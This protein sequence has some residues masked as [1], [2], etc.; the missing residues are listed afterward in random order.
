LAVE[1]V[2]Q[3]FMT[4]TYQ[5]LDNSF[6]G[7]ERYDL[8]DKPD[9][10]SQ[11]RGSLDSE[12]ID[13]VYVDQFMGQGTGSGGGSYRGI[14]NYRPKASDRGT[15]SCSFQGTVGAIDDRGNL[16]RSGATGA[17]SCKNKSF[18]D[19]QGSGTLDI[20][21][22]PF[23]VAV[24][25]VEPYDG[26]LGLI[27]GRFSGSVVSISANPYDIEIAGAS[28]TENQE[29]NE[30]EVTFA[31]TG[32]AQPTANRGTSIA[33]VRL[34]WATGTEP[35][36]ILGSATADKIPIYWNQAGGTI[37]VGGLPNPPANATHLL[38]YADSDQRVS[39]SIEVENNLCGLRL[40]GLRSVKWNTTRDSKA[41]RGVDVKYVVA[42]DTPL[43]VGTELIYYWASGPTLNSKI[44]QVA[45]E[46]LKSDEL[47]S[48]EHL[49][50]QPAH[51]GRPPADATHIVVELKRPGGSEPRL[52]PH[53][54]DWNP[55]QKSIRIHS[56]SEIMDGAIVPET[57]NSGK[58]ISAPF[59]PGGS[60]NW[61]IS[62]AEVVMGVDH[63]NWY[64]EV[65]YPT[66]M[67]IRDRAFDLGEFLG[68]PYI[69]PYSDAPGNP[70]NVGILSLYSAF[71]NGTPPDPLD[72]TKYANFDLM[73]VDLFDFY[74]D[75]VPKRGETIPEIQQNTTSVG[76]RYYDSP[77]VPADFYNPDANDA[78]EFK[79]EL[80]GI[81]QEHGLVRLSQVSE[82]QR[83]FRW[84]SN[85]TY[86]R[87][88]GQTGSGGVILYVPFDFI[89]ND[90]TTGGVSDIEP[91]QPLDELIVAPD[92]AIRIPAGV[93]TTLDV[94]A[95]ATMP[96]G[97]SFDL[98]SISP[99]HGTATLDD[100]GTPNDTTD[101]RITYQS[102]AGFSGVDSFA[103]TVRRRDEFDIA[104]VRV[105]LFVGDPMADA[106]GPY[107]VNEGGTVRLS[108]SGVPAAGTSP[109]FVWDLDGDDVFGEASGDGEFGEE[110]GA[111][112][113]M[114]IMRVDGFPGSTRTVRLRVLDD[115][116]TPIATDEAVVS[117]QNVAPTVFD[118]GMEFVKV[119]ESV[120]IFADANDLGDPEPELLYEWDL[121]GDGVFGESG[122][123]ALR[124]DEI[125]NPVSFQAVNLD[126]LTSNVVNA[127]MRVIDDDGA[128]S[129]PQAIP[130]VILGLFRAPTDLQLAANSLL[131]N[132]AGA[133]IGLLTVQ[134][135]DPVDS[136]TFDVNDDRFEV[137]SDLNLRLKPNQQVDF[138]VE[139]IITVIVTVIDVAMESF[140]AT[141]D[142][143]FVDRNDQPFRVAG[144]VGEF[145]TYEDFGV[146]PL[147]FDGLEYEPADNG[148]LPQTLTYRVSKIPP[149][150]VGR[151]LLEDGITPVTPDTNYA[152]EELENMVFEPA[153]VAVVSV[154]QFQFEVIDNGGTDLGGVD[155]LPQ[156]VTIT[157]IPNGSNS[158]PVL[159]PISNRFGNER[160]LLTFQID[161]TDDDSDELTYQ[162][163]QLPADAEFDPETRTFSWTPVSGVRG[164]FS[165]SF[166]VSDGREVDDEVIVISIGSPWHNSQII[167]DVNRDGTISPVDALIGI[168]ELNE[169]TI[170]D[171]VSGRLPDPPTAGYVVQ[172]R[173]DVNNDGL[174]SPIDVLLVLNFLNGVGDGEGE[175]GAL[176]LQTTDPRVAGRPALA[177]AK[178]DIGWVIP[179]TQADV[180]NL[181]SD[182]SSSWISDWE[183]TIDI[184]ARAK[185][186]PH[187]PGLGT[188][189]R[190][191]SRHRR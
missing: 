69:D 136:F 96:A 142:L 94:L 164:T 119:G 163:E 17:S 5:M 76:L 72:A 23:K 180:A 70:P 10:V 120:E 24:S 173:Y 143:N 107:V 153:D 117:I 42:A 171:V 147:Q 102:A 122:A 34:F 133:L 78:T 112:P 175:P 159:A 65:Y 3:D 36:N 86:P 1:V 116:G 134:D 99:A 105:T 49:H 66:Y 114:T 126:G 77:E 170:I 11:Y 184:V 182:D 165:V 39:E 22:S 186:A 71:A 80:M 172:F 88:S 152:L 25:W 93:A 97:A 141:F 176:R 174:L 37:R 124:G 109:I 4:V 41:P 6:A 155:T 128:A 7:V 50:N 51:F 91:A 74:Y 123:A 156:F 106:G 140:S 187:R 177:P 29:E 108:G 111:N 87:T 162:A 84:K 20:S 190:R 150:S 103:F 68:R 113:E 61:T 130:I 47:S 169:R 63:F 167:R 154:G 179:A 60:K 138:E 191:T 89:P 149:A 19:L 14:D 135:P 52:L 54:C 178:T 81:D 139:P 85:L 30:I 157:V 92:V 53:E 82:S 151:V 64:Q 44:S 28:W 79:T 46:T 45:R 73:P 145:V 189:T 144:L 161:A 127:Q 38:V 75:E 129:E 100:G 132:S 31:V 56:P 15:F 90:T 8:P 21:E 148:A 188:V 185:F 57:R 83:S 27:T 146:T 125:G 98:R 104:R 183:S 12:T 166:Q 110:T 18:Y 33:D 43:P 16:S 59:N 101:D 121:D 13:I 48:G 67:D 55:E 35:K 58:S 32:P 131:E 137:T 168:N 9:Y 118:S 115:T 158:V 2:Q 62:E 181:G 160:E 40:N 26:G 95:G